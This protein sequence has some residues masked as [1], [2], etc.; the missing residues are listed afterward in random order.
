MRQIET[1][2]VRHRAPGRWHARI[3]DILFNPYVNIA[4]LLLGLRLV[5]SL[6]AFT[7]SFALPLLLPCAAATSVR[8]AHATGVGFSVL[9]VWQ[10]NDACAY[11]HIADL[12]YR[13]GTGDIALFPLYPLAMHVAGTILGNNLTLSGL[14]VSGL[15]Y[16][17]AALGLYRLL[18][19]DSDPAVARRT[20]V[21]L[22]WVIAA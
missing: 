18:A 11:E 20:I 12:G 16:L 14:V 7:L 4:V 5:L 8:Q 21:Y 1:G 19:E 13:A 22:H 9:G 3:T 2:W 6:F 10:R 17:A 15:A